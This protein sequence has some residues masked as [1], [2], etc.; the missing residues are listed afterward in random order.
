MDKPGT[1]ILVSVWMIT[2]NQAPYIA[3]AIEGVL[4]QQTGF[5]VELVIGEDGSNDGTRAVILE[6]CRRYPGRINLLEDEGNLG[7]MAN[8]IRTLRACK[9]KYVALCEGDDYWSDDHKLQKQFDFMEAHRDCSFTFHAALHRFPDDRQNFIQRIPGKDRW[10][11]L[12]EVFKGNGSFI[13][14]ASIFLRREFVDPLPSWYYEVEVGDYPLSILLALNGKVRY[15]DEVMCVYRRGAPG[16][17]SSGWN[18][19]RTRRLTRSNR[20]MLR[21]VNRSTGRRHA[22]LIALN[23]FY[24]YR[25]LFVGWL[26]AV[27]GPAYRFIRKQRL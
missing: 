14:T 17:W 16:S 9:G 6:Y 18:F 26:M 5:P 11:G 19:A 10:I 15:M 22:G 27:F 7:M 25:G 23:V 3:E 4:M 1:D 20:K 21:A 13:P 24:L 12:G 8:V 2:F